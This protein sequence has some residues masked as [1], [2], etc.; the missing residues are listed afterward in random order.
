M[1]DPKVMSFAFKQHAGVFG[2]AIFNG[3]FV[4]PYLKRYY[5]NFYS[6]NLQAGDPT[7]YVS[8]F[9]FPN[10]DHFRRTLTLR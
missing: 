10:D 6:M 4:Y 3:I 1:T 7:H 5:R 2:I 8:K 9:K